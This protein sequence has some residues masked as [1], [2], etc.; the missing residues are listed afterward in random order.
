M[1]DQTKLK[2]RNDL[3]Y[4]VEKVV[5]FVNASM[6]LDHVLLCHVLCSFFFHFRLTTTT[7]MLLEVSTPMAILVRLS[8]RVCAADGSSLVAADRRFLRKIRRATSPT[9]LFVMT[10]QSPSLANIKHSSLSVLVVKVISGTGMIHG[11]K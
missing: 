5:S 11:L 3:L 4:L 1:T 8:A 6:C 2:V 7:D 9:S 10:S